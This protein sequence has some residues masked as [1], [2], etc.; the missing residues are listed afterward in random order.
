MY[1]IHPDAPDACF[2][3]QTKLL[4][5]IEHLNTEHRPVIFM[6]IG[7]PSVPGDCLGPLTGSVL[8]KRLPSIVYGT[9]DTP[10]HA[11]NLSCVCQVIKKQHQKPF[12]IAIDA[13]L[14]THTQ[15]GYIFLKKG[16]LF[17]GKGV[18]KHLPPVGHIQISGV[19]NDIFGPY[20]EQQMSRF[21]SCISNGILKLYPALQG[22]QE[23]D[24][25]NI[26]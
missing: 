13:A 16:P 22:T 19:F 9:F 2:E 4:G 20:A 1:W 24:F 18:G 5:L 7:S 8:S 6:C 17:P 14:G 12:I 26:F 10:V 3:F 15:A 25:I 21:V 23:S 11:L